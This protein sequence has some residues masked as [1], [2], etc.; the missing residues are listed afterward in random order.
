MMHLVQEDESAGCTRRIS[1]Q[2]HMSDSQILRL[3]Q[4]KIVS[5]VVYICWAFPRRVLNL[6]RGWC[7]VLLEVTQARTKEFIFS[8]DLAYFSGSRF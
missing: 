8:A 6:C 2:E 5:G 7:G 1:C 3:E 4:I